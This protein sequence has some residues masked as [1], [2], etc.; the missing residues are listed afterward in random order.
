MLTM[1]IATASAFVVA[2]KVGLLIWT[3]LVLTGVIGSAVT[4][5]KG[6]LGWFLLDLV[7]FG[8]VGNVTAFLEPAPDSFWARRSR[9]RSH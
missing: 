6:R 8:L 2:P 1:P 7:T 3:L 5:A 9:T 4:L